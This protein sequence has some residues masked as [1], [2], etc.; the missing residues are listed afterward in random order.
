MASPGRRAMGAAPS[1]RRGV[2]R[3]PARGPATVE[4]IGPLGRLLAF[5]RH[6]LRC[7]AMALAAL[8][9]AWGVALASGW[10]AAMIGAVLGVLAG[11]LLAR[12]R[13]RLALALLTLVGG[14]A[15]LWA[16]TGLMVSTEAIPSM[17]G[18]G[19]T[20]R[21]AGML[22][23]FGLAFA[24]TALLRTLAAR[25]RSMLALE[26]AAVV[27]AIATQ[28]AS[29]RDGLIAR[30][31]W[32]SDWAWQAGLDP[33]EVLLGVG[34]VAV[35][36]LAVL[37]IAE[38]RSGLSMGSLLVL[39]LLALLAMG[40]L[41]VVGRPTPKAADGLGLTTQREG[42]PPHFQDR[43]QKSHYG[44]SGRGHHGGGQGHRD[45]GASGAHGQRDGGAS[46]AHG[47]RDGGASGGHGQRD[48][49][50]SG[51]HG[52]RDGGA[53]G[54]HGQRDGGASGGQGQRDGGA[55]GGQGHRDGG[56]NGGQGHRDGG[57]NGGQG[58]RD[59]GAGGGQGHGEAGA[60]GQDAGLPS[61]TSGQGGRASQSPSGGTKQQGPSSQG[62]PQPPEFD[63]SGPSRQKAAPMAVV[64]LD[65]D[66]TPPAQYWYF[67][68]T[69]WSRYDG[70]RLV[71]DPDFDR[72]VLPSFPTRRTAVAEP[73]PA[74]GR[75]RVRA[76]VAMLVHHEGP[77]A[78]E[79]AVRFAP[80]PNPNPDRF[81]SAYRFESLAQS[82]V[83]RHLFGR[84]AG[85]PRW[86]A[87][88]RAHYLAGPA[89]PRYAKL[90]HRIVDTSLPPARR[91]DPFAEAVAIKLWLDA[92]ATYST[93]HRHA[94]V[95]D[96]TADFLFGDRIGYCVHFA[97]SAVFLWRALGIPR[98]SARATR[99]TTQ[100]PRRL[101]ESSCAAATPTPGPSSTSKARA[102]SCSTSR[103]RR[104]SIRPSR[105]GRRPAASAR[106]DGAQQAGRPR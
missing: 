81:V 56:A 23:F 27:G 62:L 69:A 40:M 43:G 87:A 60:G 94:G 102:G 96:P 85:D 38:T 101:R 14:M 74:K 11:E 39:P 63:N 6:P 72:D 61:Q 86:S 50:A 8:S 91:I 32:L 2:A 13:L 24:A 20:L 51:G 48:G 49:G 34:A 47:H 92:H 41:D 29:H 68:Q 57:A 71:A 55:S 26:L 106:R 3:A 99:S 17:L 105:P 66:Y 36:M 59:G 79:G 88:T 54:G 30:P 12:S 93:A 1:L 33:G 89:D 42:G 16:S 77:F 7:L 35:V 22:R 9:L 10:I 70:S 100:A 90:A 19:T 80:I 103:R 65:D 18:P 97:H 104:T 31:L 15:V 5:G 37:L 95:P 58:N 98:V 83:Y 53:S 46:G 52:Q 28:F 64:I 84:H 21:V 45:G 44:G 25:W 82:I 78:L 67:R 4:D 73:P 75:T 76:R